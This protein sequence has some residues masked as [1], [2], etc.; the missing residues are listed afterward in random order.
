MKLLSGILVSTGAGTILEVHVD[1]KTPTLPFKAYLRN[2]GFEDDPFSVFHPPEYTCHM[3]GRARV[4][5]DERSI[6]REVA[7]LVSQI[8]ETSME[9]G[10]DLY[11]ETELV[12]AT[13]YFPKHRKRSS[14]KNETTL[15]QLDSFTFT[16]SGKFGEARADVHIEW[17][18]GTVPKDVQ[19]YLLEKNF[20]WVGTP[21]TAHFPAEDIATLQTRDFQ[22]ARKVYDALVASPLLRCTG[23]HL[24]AKLSTK[25]TRR[26]LPMPEVINVA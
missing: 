25:A 17:I 1:L 20:Y 5:H 19:E 23:I 4:H 24:E 18:H 3:T 26:D 15:D 9:W 22:G 2:L 12:R 8:V 21:R 13:H 6:I 10:V 16:R 7:T 11:V 14:K